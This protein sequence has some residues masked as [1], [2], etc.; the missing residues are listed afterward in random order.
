M[1]F[2]HNKG[3][4]LKTLK[5]YFLTLHNCNYNTAIQ[6]KMV[7]HHIIYLFIYL[8]IYVFVHFYFH[9]MITFSVKMI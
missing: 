7:K 3:K 6:Y 4:N 5:K 8:F 9:C 2:I 1:T